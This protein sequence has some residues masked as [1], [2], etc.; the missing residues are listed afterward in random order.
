MVQ[1]AAVKSYAE[2]TASPALDATLIGKAFGTRS[3]F[4]KEPKT[5]KSNEPRSETEATCG[6]AKQSIDDMRPMLRVKE[7]FLRRRLVTAFG[8]FDETRRPGSHA[9]LAFAW[10]GHPLPLH[11]SWA[12]GNLAAPEIQGSKGHAFSQTH[13][14]PYFPLNHSNGGPLQ[15]GQWNLVCSTDSMMSRP[16]LSHRALM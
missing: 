11:V 5:G 10:S 4:P 3:T 15:V 2:P 9:P 6:S 16:Q 8:P 12:D 14:A 13:T 7:T 1:P